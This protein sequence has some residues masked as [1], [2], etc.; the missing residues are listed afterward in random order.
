M[1]ANEILVKTVN[2]QQQFMDFNDFSSVV[3]VEPNRC[4]QVYVKGQLAGTIYDSDI[5]RVKDKRKEI[6]YEATVSQPLRQR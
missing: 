6:V 1:D 5:D 4:A 2:D 3:V